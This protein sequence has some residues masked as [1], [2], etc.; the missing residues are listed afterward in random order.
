MKKQLLIGLLAVVVAGSVGVASPTQVSEAKGKIKIR[1]KDDDHRDRR[2]ELRED[3][4]HILRRTAN[5]LERAQRIARDDRD[6][7]RGHH[8]RRGKHRRQNSHARDDI[9]Y[10]GLGRAFAHQ[11]RAK[12]LFRN[13]RY[14][15][16][17]DHSLEARAIALRVIRRADRWDNDGWRDND[18][19]YY[20]YDMDRGD[21]DDREYRHWE[22]RRH[23]RSDL[24][25]D[26]R[27]IEIDDDAVI[28]F[29][30]E[31]NF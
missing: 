4:R 26:I 22:R 30:I 7:G 14:E 11:N 1:I 9:R 24:E 5:V 27:G 23:N 3:A 2:Q 10:R 21:M 25:V 19:N 16:A 17:I 29:R 13:G 12:D 18:Y 20:R 15:L 6:R 8:G 31:F 28:D